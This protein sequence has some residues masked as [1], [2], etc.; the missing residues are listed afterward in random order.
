MTL[1]YS[2][3]D[4]PLISIRS[5]D[6]Q[7]TCL[8]LP[9][10]FV[11][12]TDDRI[13]DF[14]ALRPH[15]RHPWHA[16]LV[17]LAAMALHQAKAQT[18]FID[19]ANWK[20]ALLAL[21][22]DDSDGAAWCLVTS[23]E[24]PALMQAPVPEQ[25]LQDWKNRLTTPDKLDMLVTS[26]NHDLKSNQMKQCAPEDWLMALI[27]LQ[28]QEGFLG[29]GNYGISRM[30]GGFASRPAVGV[31]PPGGWGKRW[32]RDVS[33]L[34]S[35]RAD[36]V[37]T[38]ELKEQ[39]GIGLVWLVPWTGN[40]SLSFGALDPF[41]IEICRRIRLTV[42]NH[43]IVAFST[44]SKVSRIE[45]KSRNGITGDLWMP[46]DISAAKALTITAKGFDYKLTA[47]LLF[48]QKYKG[49]LAQTLTTQDGTQGI[50][51][52]AQ[53]VT[54]GQGKTE[55]YHE[56]RIPISPKTR[57]FMLKRNTDVLA[58]IAEERVSDINKIRGVLWTALASLFD[59]GA[60]KD[61]FSDSAKDKANLFT[62]PFEYDEDRR[63]FDGSLGL[64]EQI[65]SDQPDEVR[66][67]WHLDMADRAEAILIA[68]FESGPCHGEQRYRARTAALSRLH[69]GLRS[70]K[71]LPSLADYYKKLKQ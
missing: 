33:C 5:A 27:S 10:L 35:C 70:D 37:S 53:G 7:R 20:A 21:T 4:E 12:L 55:G 68:A 51:M 71:T 30:N 42:H 45:A 56:R 39:R 3:L 6:G 52:L 9:A 1:H 18:P 26:K 49:S 29:A 36:I 24:R 22:P 19:E 15:Q 14:P 40:D 67:A 46:I 54:R 43:E 69:G 48:G 32:A 23:P 58:K 28:T 11:A 38:M 25:T 2:L 66:L 31:V 60:S 65:E 16:F 17:Q 8:S 57:S 63:F 47:E 59:G 62:R 61:K 13:H 44:G 64:N 41:Y 34:M 50:V